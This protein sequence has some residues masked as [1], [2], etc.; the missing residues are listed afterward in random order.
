MSTC[1]K[2]IKLNMTLLNI[3]DLNPAGSELFVDPDSFLNEVQ[4]NEAT[5]I[6]G[7]K[8]GKGGYGGNNFFYSGG[9]GGYGG[10]G[11]ILFSSGGGRKSGKKGGGGNI[12]FYSGGYGGGALASSKIAAEKLL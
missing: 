12:F 1:K 9:Y 3:S 5:S 10:G 7:G 4:A 8:S 2:R 6:I 11:Q